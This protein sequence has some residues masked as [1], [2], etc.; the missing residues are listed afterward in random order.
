MYI[1]NAR[2]LI[3]IAGTLLFFACKK[4][5]LYITKPAPV[6]D[7]EAQV[8]VINLSAYQKNP[9]YH[10]KI[11]DVRVSNILGGTTNPTPFPG[12]GLNT[13]GLSTADYLSIKAGSN[14]FTVATPFVGTSNDSTVIA[15]GTATLEGNKRYSVF[16][17]DT[18]TKTNFI[19]VEDTLS[20][21]DSGYAKF[22][23]VNLMPNLTALDLYIGTVKIPEASNIPFKGVSK[24]F[25]LPTNNASTT[26]AIRTAG[27][28]AN[29]TTYASASTLGNQRAYTVFARGYSTVTAATDIRRQAISFI[30][31]R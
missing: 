23:F 1:N 21:P 5:E 27:G 20:R 2:L 28:T 24:P 14:T 10:L 30:Y 9:L 7:G 31:T 3:C 26:W 12:G 8:K 25:L 11:N 13:G 22:Q 4:N 19:V 29:L 15:T 16:F 6:T 17:T 18:L